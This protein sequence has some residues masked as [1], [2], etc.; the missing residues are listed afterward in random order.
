VQ[1]NKLYIIAGLII[2]FG[3]FY[4]LAARADE[5]DQATTVTF[6]QPVQIPGQLL[7]AGTYVFKL[8]Y[9]D[10][11]QSVVQIFNSKET[12]LYATLETIP[13]DR[14]DTTGRT[15]ITL[16]EQGAG[17]PDVLLK[18][19]YPGNLTGN[20]FL[21]SDHREKDLAHAEQRTILA[22]QQPTA[23]PEMFRVGK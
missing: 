21:Y 16:A 8:A 5:S 20:E 18:W 15:V 4:V 19:F 13:T 6:N 14:R 3:L 2:A 22:D 9:R 10:T 7:P 11:D 23:N 12:H 1:I 17:K